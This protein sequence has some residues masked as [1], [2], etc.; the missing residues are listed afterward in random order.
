MLVNFK[1]FSHWSS[2][3]L[4]LAS[5]TGADICQGCGPSPIMGRRPPGVEAGGQTS[6]GDR[7]RASSFGGQR[8]L[9]TDRRR[10][11]LQHCARSGDGTQ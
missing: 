10:R 6:V 3:F 11:Q 7:G 5:P 9:A 8:P 1:A 4:G 2:C